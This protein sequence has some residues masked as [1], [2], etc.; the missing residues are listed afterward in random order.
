M[1][2]DMQLQMRAYS[3]GRWLNTMV[4]CESIPKTYRI[5]NKFMT[6]VWWN[7]KQII[8]FEIAPRSHLEALLSQLDKISELF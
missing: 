8:R 2:T 7:P 1:G 3:K 6:C 5:E 4:E